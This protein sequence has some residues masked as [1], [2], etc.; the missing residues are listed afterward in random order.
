MFESRSS[1]RQLLFC[2][3]AIIALSFGSALAD[4]RVRLVCDIWPPY[5]LKADSVITGMSVEIVQA[6][7]KRLGYDEFEIQAY[8]WM[9]AMDAV[10]FAEADALL[11]ANYTEER[12]RY[13]SYPEEPLFESPWIVWTK[14]GSSILTMEDLKG[15]KVGVVLGY[16]YTEEFNDFI[17]K[18]CNIEE[19]HSDEINFKKLGLGRLDAVV[20]E[21]GNGVYLSRALGDDSIVPVPRIEVK[22]DGL[23]IVFNRK[24]HRDD[25]V[26]RFS[27]ELKAFKLTLEHNLIRMKY[28]GMGK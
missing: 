1:L 18:Y 11:S 9:R 4:G 21:Y 27:E 17:K 2:A 7:Y 19:A 8:P 3:T 13:L 16:S 26:K 25:F 10:R 23:Y 28:L 20:A 6:V 14:A 22:K 15:K 24:L 12:S 5:Q